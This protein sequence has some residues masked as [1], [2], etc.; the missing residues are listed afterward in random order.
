M[1]RTASTESQC[2]YRTSVPVQGCTLSLPYDVLLQVE[3]NRNDYCFIDANQL[4]S[5]D[6]V[7][8]DM[9]S[10]AGTRA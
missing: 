2:L 10:N 4:I 1:D 8:V 7:A 3:I 5:S 6:I 9:C